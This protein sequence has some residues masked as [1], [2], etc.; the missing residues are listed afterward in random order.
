MR[1]GARTREWTSGEVRYLLDNAG[2]VPVG[3]ICR[4][5]RRSSASVSSMADR[6]RRHGYNVCLR[7]Y[8]PRT[9]TCPSCGRA[10]VTARETGI[11]RPC[12]LARQLNAIDAEI[13]D[14]M[15]RMPEELRAT[16][17]ETEAETGPRVADPMPRPPRREGDATRYQ[18]DRDEDEY[19]IALEQWETRRAQRRVKSA[20][21]RKE[22]MRRKLW[23]FL[24]K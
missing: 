7:H 5:L 16:Y 2:R 19:R 20:Q 14:L 23:R 18:L 3:E 13:S 17:E 4:R 6:L 11:C 21:K 15:A 9:V 10:S 24:H 12:Q 22:R 8:E 1:R